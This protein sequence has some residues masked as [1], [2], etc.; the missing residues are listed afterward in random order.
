MNVSIYQVML[1]F[2]V[3]ELDDLDLKVLNRY[4]TVLYGD[5]VLCCMILLNFMELLE[6]F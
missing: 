1:Q 3:L 5:A 2:E 4:T 6:A